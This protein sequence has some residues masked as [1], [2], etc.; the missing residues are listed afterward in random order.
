[1]RCAHATNFAALVPRDSIYPELSVSVFGHLPILSKKDDQNVR[2]RHK[3]SDVI[4][5]CPTKKEEFAD[6]IGKS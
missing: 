5:K 4:G 6:V 3:S 1:M 2:L